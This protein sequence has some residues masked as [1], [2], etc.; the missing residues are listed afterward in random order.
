[1]TWPDRP[2]SVRLSR[3]LSVKSV[4]PTGPRSFDRPVAKLVAKA[5]MFV[6]PRFR[7]QEHWTTN[8]ATWQMVVYVKADPIGDFTPSLPHIIDER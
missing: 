2:A 3:I 5:D 7:E 4:N 8:Y 1:V 6:N